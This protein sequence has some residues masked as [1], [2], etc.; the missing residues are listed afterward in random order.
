MTAQGHKRAAPNYLW[1]GIC[2]VLCIIGVIVATIY[3]P[4][5]LAEVLGGICMWA[6][7]V[8]P[9]FGIV[10]GHIACYRIKK[11]T[12]I[13]ASKTGLIGNYVIAVVIV[14]IFFFT[15]TNFIDFIS[16]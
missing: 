7:I 13:S 14:I 5:K 15:R 12:G 4:N 1:L 10:M 8:S 9:F 16:K 6:F 3:L 11:A 2:Q